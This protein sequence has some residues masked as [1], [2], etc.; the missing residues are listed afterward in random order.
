MVKKKKVL[1]E[2][3]M[4]RIRGKDD[5][6]KVLNKFNAFSEKSLNKLEDII[7]IAGTKYSQQDIDTIV[8]TT[9][10]E[11]QVWECNTLTELATKAELD[12]C[13]KQII[14]DP[15]TARK[16]LCA[17]TIDAGRARAQIIDDVVVP[18]TSPRPARILY[19]LEVSSG[20]AKKWA[21]ADNEQR[22]AWWTWKVEQERLLTEGNGV[23]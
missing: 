11:F 5:I 8:A 23:I 2:I 16:F 9:F 18:D 13:Y 20:E 12:D 22:R 21:R 15:D 1:G 10:G 4:Q 19:F 3:A 6:P 7:R 14:I 17:L